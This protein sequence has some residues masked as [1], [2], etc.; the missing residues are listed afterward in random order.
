MKLYVRE[1][2]YIEIIV[3][4]IISYLKALPHSI[5]IFTCKQTMFLQLHGYGKS[6]HIL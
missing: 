2:L 5:Q 4:D 6:K 1:E 3:L